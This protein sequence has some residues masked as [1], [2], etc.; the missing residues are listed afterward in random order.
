[1][2]HVT[3]PSGSHRPDEGEGIEVQSEHRG[4]QRLLLLPDPICLTHR[5]REGKDGE[6]GREGGEREGW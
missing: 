6:R 4:T 3:S 2:G 5:G 1:M